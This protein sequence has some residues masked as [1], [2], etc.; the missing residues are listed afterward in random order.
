MKTSKNKFR[1]KT[2]IN[3]APHTKDSKNYQCIS[4]SVTQ[5]GLLS[6]EEIGIMTYLLSNSNKFIINKDYVKSFLKLADTRGNKAWKNLID[7]GYIQ[8][9]KIQGGVHWKIWEDPEDNP[10]FMHDVNSSLTTGE[11]TLDD[12][13]TTEMAS[14]DYAMSRSH[15]RSLLEST[16]PESKSYENEELTSVKKQQVLKEQSNKQETSISEEVLNGTSI[17]NTHQ[18]NHS[19]SDDLT[20]RVM[21][22]IDAKYSFNSWWNIYPNRGPRRT[23]GN[24]NEAKKIF[25]KLSPTK[26][27]SLFMATGNLIK[28]PLDDERYYQQAD[29]FITHFD[30]YLDPGNYNFSSS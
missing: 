1:N 26:K 14:S 29:K 9:E 30:D 16:P 25:E 24:K 3:R 8:K 6:A 2:T 19:K 27:M 11:I 5:S 17:N 28:S 12:F 13:T 10:D 20:S 23:K 18:R 4:V 7:L 21:D 15:N 22:S